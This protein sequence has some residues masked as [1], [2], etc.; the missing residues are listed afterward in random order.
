MERNMNSIRKFN[1]LLV[2]SL[3]A[4]VLIFQS[5]VF[6]EDTDSLV[7]SDNGNVGIGV[8]EPEFDLD[9][10]NTISTNY[11]NPRNTAN[12]DYKYLRFGNPD[13]FWAGFMYNIS[14]DYSGDGDD[15]TIFT[16]GERDLYL[17]AK[18]GDIV[19]GLDQSTD[20][21]IGTNDPQHKLDVNGTISAN[22]LNPRSESDINKY[23]YIRFGNPDNYYAGFMYS[24]SNDYW[25][26]EE[27]FIIFTYENRDIWLRSGTGNILLYNSGNV[28]IGTKT[29]ADKL[30]VAG[31]VR[32]NGTRL[33]SDARWKENIE[34]LDNALEIVTQLQ[35]VS[36]N[37]ADPS[38]GESRQIG[39]IAQEV[40]KV[41]PEVVHTD[42]QGYKSVEYSKLVAPLIEAIKALTVKNE[43]L[44]AENQAMK[45][46]FE[47]RLSKL[48]Q[49]LSNN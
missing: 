34:P 31:Y 47:E 4:L 7:V 42:S 1:K 35:G 2:L 41:L 28:G 33:S 19:L 25:G 43:Q 39:V 3:T 11:L 20:V 40:E 45:K 30:D 36:Y 48:E 16:Y 44:Q 38:R 17:R 37:W 49:Q 32:A 46:N 13:S 26:D 23:K 27:D 12:S 8:S 10:N 6:A 22:Y 21:G 18:G 9:V 5:A 15:F 24:E 14:D 29:P